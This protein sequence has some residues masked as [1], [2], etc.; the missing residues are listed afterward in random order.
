MVIIRN[1]LFYQ[2][3]SSVII[4]T[5]LPKGK[6]SSSLWHLQMVNE[7][8][9]SLT[10]TCPKFLKLFICKHSLGMA[11]RLKKYAVCPE[12]KNVPIGQKRKRGR[13]SRAK[14]ALIVQQFT[15]IY[16]YLWLYACGKRY[17]NIYKRISSSLL[18]VLLSLNKR[19]FLW[20][21]KTG[22]IFGCHCFLFGRRIILEEP[23]FIWGILVTVH[24][25]LFCGFGFAGPKFRVKTPFFSG[26]KY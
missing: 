1:E 13:P 25:L 14:K 26:Q 9:K 8:W 23:S 21:W 19:A 20:F 10:C 12:A 6:V 7:D 15:T 3:F 18:I 16:C 11:I 22:I 5:Y 24:D 4:D 2:T 17:V